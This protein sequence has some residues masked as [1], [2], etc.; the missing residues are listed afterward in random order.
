MNQGV[1]LHHKAFEFP[2]GEIGNKL[3]IVLNTPSNDEPYL[4]CRTTSKCKYYITKEGCHHEKSIYHLK[5]N[6][7][8]FPEDTWVQL[9]P[10]TELTRNVVLKACLTDKTCRVLHNIS[11]NTIR[12]ILDCI[13]KGDDF[14]QYQADLMFK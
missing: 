13:V 4:V 2:D 5:A 11:P 1:V 8:G 7:D 6:N 12:A 9:T 14:T 10:I 3:L